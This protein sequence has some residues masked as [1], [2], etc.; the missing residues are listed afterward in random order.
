[1]IDRILFDLRALFNAF[2]RPTSSAEIK[3]LKAE[4]AAERGAF[5]SCVARYLEEDD[6]AKL[7]DRL[8]RPSEGGADVA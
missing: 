5:A 4:I 1:M 8:K 3:K 2:G 6:F 7:T